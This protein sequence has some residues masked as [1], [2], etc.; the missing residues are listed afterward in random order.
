MVPRFHTLLLTKLRRQASAVSGI[1]LVCLLGQTMFPGV[2]N[3]LMTI[4]ASAEDSSA[5]GCCVVNLA[6]AAGCCCGP[7]AGEGCGCACGTKKSSVA[8]VKVKSSLRRSSEP[9]RTIQSEI[10]GCGG[11][12][13]PG[14]VTSIEPAILLSVDEPP[15]HSAEPRI[16]ELFCDWHVGSL[17]PPTPP[18]ELIG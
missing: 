5:G 1:L 17:T 18:P 14:M 7:N 4:T 9:A 10:C 15:A 6:G 8:T 16:P 3:S 2:T 13:R 11:K 12:H